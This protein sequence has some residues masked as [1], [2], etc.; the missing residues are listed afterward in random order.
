M[1]IQQRYI[2]LLVVSIF[3]ASFMSASAS[4]M[5]RETRVILSHIEN[6]A[7]NMVD[8]ALAQDVKDAQKID[9][10][11]Q[12]GIG[13]LYNE[14]ED[15]P[16]NERRSRELLMAYSWTRV[17]SIDIR[18][19]AWVGVAIAANQLSASM[20]RFTHYPSLR[21]RD[22]AWM[23]YL[24]REL[25]LLNMENPKLNA[26]LLNIRRA[27]LNST[28]QRISRDLIENFHNKPYVI[29]G[30]HLM[31]EMN[32]AKKPDQVIGLTRKLL[33]FVNKIKHVQ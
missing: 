21:Q 25:L 31:L 28:W 9:V 14:L 33:T 29:E 12:Q 1:F 23:G 11:I 20:F 27:D 10:E 15:Q 3:I 16:F 26:E 17:I 24:S 8:A 5:P 2:L 13:K 6:N 4:E 22:I 7:E 32:K 19:K 18:Q 30:K